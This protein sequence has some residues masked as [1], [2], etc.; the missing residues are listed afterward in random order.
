LTD[1]PPLAGEEGHKL[2][3]SVEIKKS[4]EYFSAFFGDKISEFK[5]KQYIC[6][7]FAKIDAKIAQLPKD[8]HEGALPT[9]LSNI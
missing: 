2:P 4:G 5:K 8:R 1:R 6:S 7:R 9:E 3:A